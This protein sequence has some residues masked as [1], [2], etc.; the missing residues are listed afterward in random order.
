MDLSGC[1]NEIYQEVSNKIKYLIDNTR[2]IGGNEV[3]QFELEFA[4]YC[5]TEYAIACGN[6]T[7][8][9]TLALKALDIK[10]GDTVVTVS[11]TFIATS[12]A[13]SSVGA[14]V[15]FV[16]IDEKTYTMDPIKLKE[17]LR[18]YKVIKNVKAVIPVHLYGQM[19]DMESI[20]AIAKEFDLK[21]IEDSA[22]AH[23]AK[24]NGKGPGEYGDIATFSFYPGK[25]LGAFG[26]GGA[27]VTNNEYL[28]NKIKMLSNH[29]RIKK[30][31][32]EMEGYNSRL[33]SI[34]A[35]ILRVK[36]RHLNKWNSMRINNANIYKQL[37]NKNNNIITPFIRNES[38]HVFHLF[39]V[40]LTN[41][42]NVRESLKKD[43]IATG[44]HYPIPL[45][46]QPAYRYL[47]YKKGDFPISEKISNEILSLPMWPELKEEDINYVCKKLNDLV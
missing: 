1:Y 20:M 40:R 30:Y 29:G 16:D 34:Q 13:I 14:S 31:E 25:N 10:T 23:G 32:H 45:H 5:N 19:A 12:E 46:L 15:D 11:N 26:D 39:T 44:I 7:D 6:G 43:G 36:L 4:K 28:A 27:L 24:F 3:E 21:V 33:D 17:Y 47:G 18:K 22:Q 9:L 37:L 2:F 8:A 35:A 42:D 38:R 41:R